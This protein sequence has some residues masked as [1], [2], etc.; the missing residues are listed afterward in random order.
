MLRVIR[1]IQPTWIVGENVPGI[2]RM[3]L[4]NI[5]ASLE[6]ENYKVQPVII[7]SASIGAWD[8]RDRVWIIAYNKKSGI[9][10]L[11]IQQRGQN[12]TSNINPNREIKIN[13]DTESTISEQSRET[14]SRGDGLPKTCLTNQTPSHKLDILKYRDIMEGY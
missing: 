5:C 1:E 7:P 14:W 6:S 4:E 13:P 2:I 9:R 8:K 3:E 10:E 11:P 12:K